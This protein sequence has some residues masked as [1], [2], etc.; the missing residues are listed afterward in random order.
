MGKIFRTFFIEKN[1]KPQ[2]EQRQNE[3]SYKVSYGKNKDEE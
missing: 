2:I 3:K 1:I